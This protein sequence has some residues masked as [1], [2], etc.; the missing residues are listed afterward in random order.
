MATTVRDGRAPICHCDRVDDGAVRVL[1]WNVQGAQGL[2]V[3]RT[4]AIIG[5]AAP[6]VVALQEIQRRQ[7]MA[8]ARALSAPSRRWAFKHWPVRHRS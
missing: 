8:L 4:A 1:T 7:A 5:S 3:D 2:D 6:D